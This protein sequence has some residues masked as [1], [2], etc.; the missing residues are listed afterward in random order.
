MLVEI[1]VLCWVI[2]IWY[3]Y[4][5]IYIYIHTYTVLCPTYSA[6]IIHQGQSR[7]VVPLKGSGRV[8]NI[9]VLVAVLLLLAGLRVHSLTSYYG[10]FPA[11][12][13][14]RRVG[15]ICPH[16]NI[17]KK[18][19]SVCIDSEVIISEQH[20]PQSIADEVFTEQGNSIKHEDVTS[21]LQDV[22]PT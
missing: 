14:F 2:L 18:H 21:P 15:L 13:F 12:H 5:Y 10:T 19:L 4:I 6:G 11:E 16:R 9:V 3:I 17:E 7:Q 22:L 8:H 20:N 1:T